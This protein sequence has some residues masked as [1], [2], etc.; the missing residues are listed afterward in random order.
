MTMLMRLLDVQ[1]GSPVKV[2]MSCEERAAD[3][4]SLFFDKYGLECGE[5]MSLGVQV[6]VI[7]ASWNVSRLR[8]RC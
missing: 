3:S 8:A 1:I 5:E 6:F 2:V 4:S 7:I